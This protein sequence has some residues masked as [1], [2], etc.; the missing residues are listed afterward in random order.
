MALSDEIK[1]KGDY[2]AGE[3]AKKRSGKSEDEHYEAIGRKFE[4]L[5]KLCKE[6]YDEGDDDGEDE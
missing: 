5:I 3:M 6:G 2:E 1:K 4:E